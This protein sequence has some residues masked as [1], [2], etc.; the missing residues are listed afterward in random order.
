MRRALGT[1]KSISIQ[2]FKTFPDRVDLTVPDGVTAVVGPNG[3]G[4]SNIAEAV[5]WVLGEQ[6]ARVM[7]CE[8]KMEEVIFHGS[9]R[10]GALG[11]AEVSLV[12]GNEG[13]EFAA[14]SDEVTLTRRLYRSGESEYFINKAAVRLKD[15]ISM[16]MDTGLG[17]GGYSIIAQGMIDRIMTEKPADRRGVFEEAAGIAKYRSRKEEAQRKLGAA[18]Q[19]L[20]RVS[21]KIG[22]LEPQVESLREQA[23]TARRFLLLRDEQRGV[24]INLWLHQLETIRSGKDRQNDR[25][26]EAREQFERSK[27]ELDGLYA[28]LERMEQ[29]SME[30][31]QTAETVRGALSE[32]EGKR[33]ETEGLLKVH[34]NDIEHTERLRQDLLLA[35]ERHDERAE[36][37]R[38]QREERAAEQERIETALKDEELALSEL[39]LDIKRLAEQ[40]GDLSAQAGALEA[41][42]ALEQAALGECKLRI[43]SL[44]ARRGEQA[45]RRQALLAER[46]KGGAAL[47]EARGRLGHTQ[48]KLREARDTVAEL[49]NVLKGYALRVDQREKKLSEAREQA[50]ALR[51][52]LHEKQSRAALLSDLEK[53]YEG[54]HAVAMV[55]NSNLP[56]LHGVLSS[57]IRTKDETAVA[58]EIALGAALQNIVVSSEEDA[59]A[60][61][62]LLKERKGGR[63]TFLPL[64][65]IDGREADGVPGTDGESLG[66]ASRLV[67]CEDQYRGVVRSLLGRT[68]VCRTLDGAIALSRKMGQRLR[69]VTLDGQVVN[70]GGAMTGGSIGKKIGVLSRKNELERLEAELGKLAAQSAGAGKALEEAERAFKAARYDCDVAEDERRGAQEDAAALASE[71]S[72]RGALLKNLEHAAAI[73]EGELADIGKTLDEIDA[74]R[75]N[76]ALAA[77]GHAAAAAKLKDE[78]S[79]LAASGANL[80]V[81]GEALREKQTAQRE[82]LASLT[83]EREGVL[84]A[85]EELAE[86]EKDFS[87]DGESRAA[88]LEGYQKRGE[89]LLALCG[90]C[91]L[92]LEA[93]AEDLRARREEMDGTVEKQRALEA[94]RVRTGRLIK[95]GAE[96]NIALSRA[97]DKLENSLL[98]A[99]KDEDAL[100]SRLWEQY[101]LTVTKAQELRTPM[102]SVS[103]AQRRSSELK[104]EI[105]ALGNVNV[106]AIEQYES[107]G[108]RYRFLT[109]QRADAVQSKEELESIIERITGEMRGIFADRFAAIAQK[110]SE[111]FVEIFGGGEAALELDD[112][113]DI[114][115]SGV[116]IKARPPGK[117][118]RSISLLSGGEQ[119]LSAIALYFAI[120]KA[121]PAPFCVLDEIDHDLDDVNVGRF[122]AYLK[123]LAANT[124]YIVVTHRRGT[125]EQA[126]MLYG[127]TAQE[128]GVSKV[129]SLKLEDVEEEYAD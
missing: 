41:Q 102:E 75:E 45:A 32:T 57:L 122:A 125:M 55:M 49:D 110:F 88:A 21:D 25:Y 59:K 107:V 112:G 35:A 94:D 99:Q 43:A 28:A 66:L 51:R 15:I 104:R 126:G 20:L 76:E 56:G 118:L 48:G 52:A 82:R 19:N 10:R 3:S 84:K 77:E 120:F 117:K 97:A 129:I 98:T 24:E 95:D 61:I 87:L 12:I 65:S 5:R 103:K 2:G 67:D 54:N 6:N 63:A 123:R 18:E 40:T 1:L 80:D 79:A 42:A 47:E 90:Q 44:E 93:F 109:E 9:E 81:S 50:E 128:P 121:R 60:A 23:E 72:H 78:T 85:L 89:E 127:V 113:V 11:F 31:A 53:E 114:L 4:K 17:P 106:G 38:K 96:Q 124:Q 111:T 29:E 30:L 83:A 39:A 108:E 116:E 119:S 91:R 71:E 14:D 74:E 68:L 13:R 8:K 115:E 92:E 70:A 86:R 58:V 100:I 26:H 7:R 27:A 33:A 69:V 105:A 22:E 46:D 36:A 37:L 62:G 64:T 34:Q 101:E 16:L 73:C